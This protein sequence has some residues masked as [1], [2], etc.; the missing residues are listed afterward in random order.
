LGLVKHDQ[1][2]EVN[3]QVVVGRGPPRPDPTAPSLG[4]GFGLKNV[5]LVPGLSYEELEI[6]EG[7]EASQQLFVVLLRSDG[8]KKI[9]ISRLRRELMKYCEIDTRALARLHKGLL[10]LAAGM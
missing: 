7:G 6:A 10:E 8:M 9:E 1:E 3:K 5:A 2:G 4:G